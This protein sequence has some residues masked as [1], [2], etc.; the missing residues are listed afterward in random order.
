VDLA[1]IACMN[2]A[3]DLWR[4]DSAMKSRARVCLFKLDTLLF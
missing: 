3:T 1:E 4:N 2:L